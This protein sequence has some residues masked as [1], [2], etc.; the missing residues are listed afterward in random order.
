M[1][2]FGFLKPEWKRADAAVRQRAVARLT[3][4][5]PLRQLADSD[6]EERVRTAARARLEEL[7][8]ERAIAAQD[9]G[10]SVG[11]AGITTPAALVK[12][13]RN[14]LR[15]DL[16]LAAIEAASDP[17]LVRESLAGTDAVDRA[18]ALERV[19]NPAVL[20]EVARHDEN[21]AVRRLA[22]AR[23]DGDGRGALLARLPEQVAD[24]LRDSIGDRAA[25]AREYARATHEER[26]RARAAV[27]P[28]AEDAGA[29]DRA[30][31]FDRFVAGAK[32]LPRIAAIAFNARLARRLACLLTT[33][34]PPEELRHAAAIEQALDELEEAVSG[35]R[36]QF[37]AADPRIDLHL[38]RTNS[39]AAC[40]KGNEVLERVA[41][42]VRSA[43]ESARKSTPY[44]AT[45]L[46]HT[47]GMLIT[48]KSA[49]AGAPTGELME[50]CVRRDLADLERVLAVLAQASEP[51]R[52]GIPPELFG[53][54]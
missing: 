45:M 37:D 27:V 54:P 50:A 7:A 21:W 17:T 51:E 10:A 18:Y 46:L 14:A 1:E 34:C 52:V 2:W 44:Y 30:Q 13:A 29:S 19:G 32:R 23:L 36:T 49:P 38:R 28:A 6:P 25:F 16:R 26:L 33:A 11:L 20:I 43:V 22:A 15:V 24:R 8:V 9:G 3:E 39:A 31:V 48:S 35:R 12:V 5:E 53:P 40:W 42:G 47:S 41:N 4:L